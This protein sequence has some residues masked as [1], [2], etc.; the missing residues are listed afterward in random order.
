MADPSRAITEAGLKT[1]L[2][3]VHLSPD[4]A[5]KNAFAVL[6]RSRAFVIESSPSGQ[7]ASGFTSADLDQVRFAV[8]QSHDP[9]AVSAYELLKSR[10][11]FQIEPTGQP[12]TPGPQPEAA[13]AS[14][15][16]RVLDRVDAMFPELVRLKGSVHVGLFRTT[17]RREFMAYWMDVH[18]IHESVRPAVDQHRKIAEWTDVCRRFDEQT[19]RLAAQ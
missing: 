12:N 9:A 14:A 2:L 19:S 4:P 7:A 17:G 1:V 18:T 3:K 5:V 11:V 6:D 8:H 10:N 13:A 15:V 16:A